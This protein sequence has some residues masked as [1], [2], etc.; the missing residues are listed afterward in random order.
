MSKLMS[1]IFALRVRRGLNTSPQQ[2][3]LLV[4]CID[5]EQVEVF[6]TAGGD[7]IGYV[8]WMSLTPESIRYVRDFRVLPPYP[9][10]WSEGRLM[11]I[12][13]VVFAHG[14]NKVVLDQMAKKLSSYRL[15]SYFKNNR[16]KF[17]N[18][19]VLERFLDLKAIY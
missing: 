1:E 16:L 12:F 4:A 18:R 19:N 11:M 7:P 14:W 15:V 5:K 3:S 6:R 2:L 10:E 17:V 8:A 13:D 9:Y